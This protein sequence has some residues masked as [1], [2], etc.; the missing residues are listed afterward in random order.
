LIE[1]SLSGATSQRKLGSERGITGC[2]PN[3][4]FIHAEKWFSGAD[5]AYG[6]CRSPADNAAAGISFS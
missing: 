5:L 6:Y 3:G 4:V 1:A 2:A